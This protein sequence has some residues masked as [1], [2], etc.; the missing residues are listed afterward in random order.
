MTIS[1]KCVSVI[2]GQGHYDVQVCYTTV[3][4]VGGVVL[5]AY[6]VMMYPCASVQQA[7]VHT[8]TPPLLH[9]PVL[10][11]ISRVHG[12]LTV[13]EV[14]RNACPQ[15]ACVSVCVCLLFEAA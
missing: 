1:V 14:W 9:L 15:P 10:A 11:V 3:Y 5:S 2:G 8:N 12:G 7:A 6:T 13:R 4:C